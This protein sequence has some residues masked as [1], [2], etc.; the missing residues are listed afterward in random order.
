RKTIFGQ[1][2]G[3]ETLQQTAA[4]AEKLGNYNVK[5]ILDYGVEGGNNGEAG[6][7]EATE[8]F[9]D[10]INYAAS[11]KN[12]P[13]MSIKVTGIARGALLE[14]LDT[15]IKSRQGSLINRY[16][17]A[18]D[19]LPQNEKDTQFRNRMFQINLYINKFS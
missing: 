5:V 17:N 7:D 10:V 1:F 8:V 18:L 2:V 14:K 13:F 19:A 6:F 11:Q 15:S 16:N 3:G 9:K 4:V 12:V